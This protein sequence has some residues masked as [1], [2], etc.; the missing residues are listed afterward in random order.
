M[1]RFIVVSSKISNQL[2]KNLSQRL[3]NLFVICFNLAM[4]LWLV[5]CKNKDTDR[6]ATIRDMYGTWTAQGLAF[7]S[8][9]ST[10]PQ[11]SPPSPPTTAQLAVFD[12]F[13]ADSYTFGNDGTYV[14]R[15]ADSTLS[16]NTVLTKLERG[17]Y[18]LA[19][20]LLILT[21]QDP[22]TKISRNRYYTCQFS[23]SLPGLLD[24]RILYLQTTKELLLRALEEQKEANP[25][26]QQTRDFLLEQT[27]FKINQTLTQ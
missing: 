17:T 22:I 3:R 26:Y 21:T 8:G 25:L 1:K 20:G 12:D 23:I 13:K 16:S 4:V 2:M 27:L 24:E 11:L 19:E 10:T 7:E 14:K 18:K 15:S 5:G 9:G 6:P